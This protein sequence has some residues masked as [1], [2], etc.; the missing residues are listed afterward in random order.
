MSGKDE[1]IKD[2]S[3]NHASYLGKILSY[4]TEKIYSIAEHTGKRKRDQ[5]EEEGSMFDDDEE[6]LKPKKA[7]KDGDRQELCKCCNK[8]LN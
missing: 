5:T 6:D 8:N 4:I 2:T 7:K 1:F 3:Q